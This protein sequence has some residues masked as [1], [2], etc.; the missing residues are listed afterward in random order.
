[1]E[2]IAPLALA[3]TTWDNVG[4]LVENPKPNA[5]SRVM[6]TI[7]L[8]PAHLQECIE[9]QIGVIVSYH[10]PI[11]ASMKRLTLKNPKQEIVL[12]TVAEGMSIFSPHTSLDAA[13]G[14]MNDWLASIVDSQSDRVF[15]IIPT[16]GTEV[17]AGS[18]GMGRVVELRNPISFKELVERV[19]IGLGIPTVR[20]SAPGGQERLVRRVAVCV[21]S[22]TSVFKSLKS[23][24]VDVLLSGEMGHHDVLAAADNNQSV[25]LT[26]HTNTERGFLRAV[27]KG[28]L[29]EKLG[30]DVAIEV[31]TRDADPLVVW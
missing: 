28:A 23:G 7:D 19:K 4:I 24:A 17:S 3:D 12:R 15:P 30:E 13:R 11:F 22:G 20:V 5:Y 8:T 1:M 2:Q 31:S 26:E 21:G 27:L 14:G 10:P 9:K 6:L 25:I 16:A 29:Q 18:T